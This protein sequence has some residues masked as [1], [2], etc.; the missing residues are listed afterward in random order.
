MS[1]V[2]RAR[3]VARF[4]ATAWRH[5]GEHALDSEAWRF[6]WNDRFRRSLNRVGSVANVKEEITMKLG[7]LTALTSAALLAG[8]TFAM[9]QSNPPSPSGSMNQP[10]AAQS[11]KCWDSASQMIKDKADNKN[12]TA[13]GAR[14]QGG[15]AT[16]ASPSGSASQ[17]TGSAQAQ[18]PAAAAG[19]PNC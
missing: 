13:S 8:A 14:N 5:C 4:A 1:A 2:A 17:T 11:G 9:A 10:S 16:G 3:R 6:Q 18:R 15:V 12:Q 7:R 19:L